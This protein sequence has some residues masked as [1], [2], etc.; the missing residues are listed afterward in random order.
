LQSNS[1]PSPVMGQFNLPGGLTVSGGSLFVGDTV[2]NRVQAW[3]RVEDALA[4]KPPDVV[5]GE[6]DLNDVTPEIGKDK[7]FWPSSVSFDG[8]YLWVGEYKFS[9]RVVRFSVR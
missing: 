4:G 8:S 5:L 6:K 3:K 1:K 7:L 2:N 9:G